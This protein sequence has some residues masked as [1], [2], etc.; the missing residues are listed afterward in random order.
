MKHVGGRAVCN[1]NVKLFVYLS[2]DDCGEAE[3]VEYFCAISPDSDAAILPQ[4]LIVKTINLG[5]LPGLMVASDQSDAI[6]ISDLGSRFYY[7]F[8]I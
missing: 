4:A 5:N 7:T 1:P 8:L 3:I 6:G 2:I